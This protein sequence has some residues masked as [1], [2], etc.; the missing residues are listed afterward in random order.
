MVA[1]SEKGSRARIYAKSQLTGQEFNGYHISGMEALVREPVITKKEWGVLGIAF[2]TA[3]NFDSFL[4]AINL[5][6]SNDYLII[7]PTI[8]LTTYSRFR[9]HY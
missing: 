5:D 4:G 7:L 2:S 3:L 1:D 9:V 8:R 6:W